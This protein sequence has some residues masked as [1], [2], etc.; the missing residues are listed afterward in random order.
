M[1]LYDRTSAINIDWDQVLALENS[2]TRFHKLLKIWP[3]VP[4]DQ[5]QGLLSN[6]WDACDGNLWRYRHQV[7][8]MFRDAG[9]CGDDL[10]LDTPVTL[11]RG[12]AHSRMARGVSWTGNIIVARF[13]A[14]GGRFGPLGGFVYEVQA[15]PEAILG[16]FNERHED[17][18]IVDIAALPRLRRSEIVRPGEAA[19][20]YRSHLKEIGALG[21]F[22]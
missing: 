11:Y 2:M 22:D 8:G 15:P 12:T 3:Q 16:H 10:A 17:E 5:R 4:R 13:F 1:E 9:Y 14:D 19:E 20:G 7:I 21:N 18:Y 6:W